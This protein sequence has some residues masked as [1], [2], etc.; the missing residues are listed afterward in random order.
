MPF[1]TLASTPLL[2]VQATLAGK[3]EQGAACSLV[4]AE[5]VCSS[6][7]ELQLFIWRKRQLQKSTAL[8]VRTWA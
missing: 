6:K 5:W 3:G 4:S 1:I 8:T 2:N 7:D